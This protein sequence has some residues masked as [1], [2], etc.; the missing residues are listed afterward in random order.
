MAW[1]H[2]FE[3]PFSSRFGA[4]LHCFAPCELKKEPL[5]GPMEQILTPMYSTMASRLH[6][7]L[8]PKNLASRANLCRRV[9]YNLIFS[10]SARALIEDCR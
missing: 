8:L 1:N 4:I 3:D 9:L 7:L 2:T 6:G 5:H 10:L